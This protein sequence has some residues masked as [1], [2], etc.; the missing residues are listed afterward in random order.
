MLTLQCQFPP[1]SHSGGFSGGDPRV[2]SQ[3]SSV[4][5]FPPALNDVET[6]RADRPGGSRGAFKWAATPFLLSARRAVGGGRFGADKMAAGG[7]AA[8][9]PECR[10]LPYALLPELLL[11]PPTFPSKCRVLGSCCPTVRR[12]HGSG[13]RA[14]EGSQAERP[15][16]GLGEGDAR[17]PESQ[18]SCQE[19]LPAPASGG[20]RIRRARSG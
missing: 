18:C 1:V 5:L 14:V 16:R 3:P 8:A 17:P 9:A 20:V 6:W 2:N 19:P 12:K 10:L 11:P 4:S 13:R 7:A 15:R